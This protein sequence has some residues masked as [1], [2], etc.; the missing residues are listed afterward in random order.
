M[1]TTIPVHS[2]SR[3]EPLPSTAAIA[4]A[5]PVPVAGGDLQR[6]GPRPEGG[7][8]RRASRGPRFVVATLLSA[9]TLG[10]TG[11]GIAVA[12]SAEPDPSVS[13]ATSV[14]MPAAQHHD[15]TTGEG[16]RPQDRPAR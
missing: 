12:R 13:A 5:A 8:A 14:G 9:L 1:G 7:P 6:S 15:R 16:S 11:A 2:G 3:W 4:A 10:G